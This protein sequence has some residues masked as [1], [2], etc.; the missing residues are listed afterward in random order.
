MQSCFTP[1]QPALKSKDSGLFA[2]SQLQYFRRSL[3]WGGVSQVVSKGVFVFPGF[4]AQAT[5]NNLA[6]KAFWLLPLILVKA[7]RDPSHTAAS[8]SAFK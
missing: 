2:L 4:Q 6:L 5:D 1:L 7:V 8:H 3:F